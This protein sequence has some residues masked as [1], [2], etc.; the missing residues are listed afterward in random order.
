MARPVPEPVPELCTECG[1]DEG[2]YEHEIYGWL[3]LDCLEWLDPALLTPE[4]G[5]LPAPG[6]QDLPVQ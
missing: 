5:N 6:E 2:P 3:C 1:Y 4:T